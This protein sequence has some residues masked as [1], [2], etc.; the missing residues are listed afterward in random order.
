MK[1]IIIHAGFHPEMKREYNGEHIHKVLYKKEGV[2]AREFLTGRPVS[3]DTIFYKLDN[4]AWIKGI[5]DEKYVTD[6]TNEERWGRVEEVE[7]DDEGND[8]SRQ[9]LG[10]IILRVDR[11]KGLL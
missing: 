8:I 5:G 9:D 4:D 3:K 2:T 10:F 11:S 7:Y 1:E 6:W